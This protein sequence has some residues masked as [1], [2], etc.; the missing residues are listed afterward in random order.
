VTD[1]RIRNIDDWVLDVHRQQAK[2]QG[3]TLENAAR[4]ILTAAALARKQQIAAEHRAAL[5]ELQNK[6]G[7]FSDSAALI[8]EER[9]RRG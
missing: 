1:L 4:E 7:V 5:Q 2:L 9:D 6:Y 3:K 8:R